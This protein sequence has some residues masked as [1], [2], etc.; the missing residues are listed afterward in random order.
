M[1]QFGTHSEI[2]AKFYLSDIWTLVALLAASELG[3]GTFG[4]PRLAGIFAFFGPVECVFERSG[5][6]DDTVATIETAPP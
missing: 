6:L 4:R 5:W 1:I 2:G 3:G